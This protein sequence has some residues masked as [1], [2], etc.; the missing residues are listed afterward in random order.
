MTE[1]GQMIFERGK[2]EGKAEGKVELLIRVLI[3]K[4]KSVPQQYIDKIKVL[5]EV[6]VEE[7]ATDIFE[8]EKIQDLE[9]YFTP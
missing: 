7:I 4:F 6:V 5:P 8:L 2:L 1:V 3:K 9:K